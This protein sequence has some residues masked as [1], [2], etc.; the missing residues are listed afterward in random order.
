MSLQEE[1]RWVTIARL[2][3]A[4]GNRGGLAAISLTSKPER[5]QQ[6]REVFLFRDGAPV[7]AGGFEVES[8][9]E[10]AR[11]WIFKFRG[12]DTIS[13]AELLERAEVRIPLAERLRSSSRSEHYRVGPDGMR[14]AGRAR[15]VSWW[16]W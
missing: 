12:V 1:S 10:H 2:G 13:D 8:V 15:L 14:S 4:W 9:R 5:F 7:G 16:A 3:R 6:L 11:E